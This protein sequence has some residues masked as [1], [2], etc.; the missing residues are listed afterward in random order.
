MSFPHNKNI[1]VEW[2]EWKSKLCGAA[3]AKAKKK[4]E[5][6]KITEVIFMVAA[7]WLEI[8]DGDCRR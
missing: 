7:V 6:M 5:I 1:I 3:E 2:S 8:L 4:V